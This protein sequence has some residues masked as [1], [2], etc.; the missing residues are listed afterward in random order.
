MREEDR[1]Y[2]SVSFRFRGVLTYIGFSKFLMQVSYC[3]HSVIALE[4]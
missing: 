2:S 3:V 1:D 4:K